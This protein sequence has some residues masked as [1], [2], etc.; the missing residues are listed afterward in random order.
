MNLN[1]P[2]LFP[3]R[4]DFVTTV[5][6][7]LPD[8]SYDVL[9]GAD[10][11]HCAAEFAAERTNG[12]T[13]VITDKNVWNLHGGTLSSSLD[14]VGVQ[15]SV[16]TVTPGESSK[17]L[18]VLEY[19]CNSLSEFGLG[20][21]GL[22]VAFGGGVIGDLAGFAASIWMRG[23]EYI[24]VPTTL[25]SQVDSS[26]GG[27]TAVNLTGGK[28]LV[29]SFYQP[30]L[31]VSDVSLLETLPEREFRCGVAEM[32]KYGA[33][34]SDKL[35]R[36]FTEPFSKP[37]LPSLIKRC[38][39]L[40]RDAVQTDERDTGRRVLLNFG[41]TFGHA[42][43]KL[44]GFSE[45]NH[46][47]SVGIGMLLAAAVGERLSF[48]KSGCHELLDAALKIQ[49]LPMSCPYSAEA[50]NSAITLD[51]KSRGGGVDLVLLRNIGNADTFWVSSEQLEAL[52][53]EVIQ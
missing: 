24:Q 18:S 15:Y 23:C 44:G 20:R 31:V 25:L 43:E 30:Q 39:E 51:K 1:L 12:K 32:I 45:Y 35:F 52:L 46:G 26:V 37:E 29:G 48:T 17:T 7:C 6:V 21:N 4:S 47:E 8:N 5:N 27:K 16:I 53:A 10:I 3:P 41:H 13:V 14:S 42:V 33:L 11:L 2:L 19:V 34:Y 50:L 49:G 36:K 9:I 38:C 40:K 28:N 22:I